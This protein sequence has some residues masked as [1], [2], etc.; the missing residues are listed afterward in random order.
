MSAAEIIALV[1]GISG[2]LGGVLSYVKTRAEAERVIIDA[3]EAVIE[4]LRKELQ[5]QDHRHRRRL[6]ELSAEL[7]DLE[8]RAEKLELW[9]LANTDTPIARIIG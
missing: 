8:H 6:A 3:A 9:I 2:L 4:I 5:D 1:A 7:E